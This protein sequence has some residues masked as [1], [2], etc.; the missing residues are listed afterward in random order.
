MVDTP[1]TADEL[2]LAKDS[3]SRSL[4]GLFEGSGEAA[5]ALAEIFLYD[6]SSDYYAKLPER[7]NAVTAEDAEAVAKKYLHPD[8]MILICVG[9]RAKIEPE[10]NKL[11]LGEIEIRDADGKLIP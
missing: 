3:Q 5:G 11:N 4:P 10:L 1:M 6:L 8:Q 9:D 7:L 2:A